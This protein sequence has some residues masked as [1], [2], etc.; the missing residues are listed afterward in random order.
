MWLTHKIL[1]YVLSSLSFLIIALRVVMRRIRH[2][3]FM[4]DDYLMCAAFPCFMVIVGAAQVYAADGSNKGS[5]YHVFH[6]S[7]QLVDGLHV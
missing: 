3:K 2:E 5:R 6:C 1:A 7:A 4:A